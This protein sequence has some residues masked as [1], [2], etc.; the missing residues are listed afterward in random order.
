MS[1]II[2]EIQIKATR[3][4]LTPVTEAHIKESETTGVGRDMFQKKS[5]FISSENID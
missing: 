4:H 3:Y 5:S 1:L 2:R